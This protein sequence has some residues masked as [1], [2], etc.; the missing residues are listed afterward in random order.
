MVKLSEIIK[1]DDA[2]YIVHI[3]GGMLFLSWD[4]SLWCMNCNQRYEANSID[5]EGHRH[6]LHS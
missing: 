3:C 5:W 1:R 2:G 4:G 6:E